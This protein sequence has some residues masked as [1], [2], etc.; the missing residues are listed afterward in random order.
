M[1]SVEESCGINVL[2]EMV[3]ADACVELTHGDFSYSFRTLEA[4]CMVGSEADPELKVQAAT[5]WNESR[6]EELGE[7][8]DVSELDKR[9]NFDWTF[10]TEY[11]GTCNRDTVPTEEGIDFHTLTRPDPIL[12]FEEV[13]LFE[14]EL[15]DNGGAE[16]VVFIRV[17]PTCFY[18][19]MRY[20]LRVDGVLFRTHET[21]LFHSFSSDYLIREYTV[22]E[23]SH[24]KLVT[25][26]TTAGLPVKLTDGNIVSRVLLLKSEEKHKIQI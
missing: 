6:S 23:L 14:D 9:V 7:I 5:V 24:D 13:I 10:S 2:P 8:N 20:F 25:A 26:L 16:L 3:F 4:L 11:K 19:L 15:A 1:D 12:F 22:K 21:R 17:M 18:V